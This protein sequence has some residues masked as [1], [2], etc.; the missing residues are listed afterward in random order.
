M[1]LHWT[2][3]KWQLGLPPPPS[4]LTW[5]GELPWVANG[6]HGDTPRVVIVSDAGDKAGAMKVAQCVRAGGGQVWSLGGGLGRG[7]YLMHSLR[8]ALEAAEV[9]FEGE[10]GRGC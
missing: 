2:G 6:G 9:R 10:A 5:D 7:G 8:D 1:T 3:A 4:K